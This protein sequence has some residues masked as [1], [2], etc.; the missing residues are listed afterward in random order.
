MNRIVIGNRTF[1]DSIITSI[2]MNESN[3]MIADTLAVDELV[4]DM[5]SNEDDGKVYTSN[6]EWYHT[7]NNE[8]FRVGEYYD[9]RTLT[10]G[11]AVSYYQDQKLVGKFALKSVKRKS[12]YIYE[13]SCISWVG[14]MDSITHYGGLYNGALLGDVL[15]D[16]LTTAGLTANTDFTIDLNVYNT[17]VAGWLPVDSCRA[18]MQ[19]A[20]FSCGASI[21]KDNYGILHF[22]FN[23]PTEAKEIDADATYEGGSFEYPALATKVIVT[24]HEYK[25]N[26]TIDKEVSLYDTG[27]ENVTDK[28]VTFSKPCYD[29]T[30]SGLTISESGANYAIV[31]GSG[32][33]IGKEY[34]H[35]T[36]IVEVETENYGLTDDYE[37]T[38]KDATLVTLLNSHNL[39]ER[40]SAYHSV[41]EIIGTSFVLDDE[42]PM[43][44]INIIDPYGTERV[45]Y[46]KEID[47]IGSGI[48]KANA[49][50]VTN[51]Q[52]NHVGN[53]Y[54]NYVIFTND[55][56]KIA[57]DPTHYK[58]ITNGTITLPADAVGTKGRFILFGGFKGGNGGYDGT[59]GQP[60]G[61][62]GSEGRS[63]WYTTIGRGGDGGQ[64]GTGGS[65]VMTLQA[66]VETLVGSYT[67]SVGA[68]GQGG[69][70]NGGVGQLGG[71]TTVVID[72]VTKDTDN[73]SL[74]TTGVANALSGDI[75]GMNGANGCAGGKGAEGGSQ[76][77][78]Y[79]YRWERE[80]VYY[81]P[82]GQS[83]T[84]RGITANG[85]TGGATSTYVVST[86][87]GS[88]NTG[89][90]GGGAAYNVAGGNGGSGSASGV[91]HATAGSG[92]QGADAPTPTSGVFATCGGGGYGGGGGGGAGKC[93][94]TGGSQSQG[95][96]YP[97]SGGRGGYG[98]A[99][100]NGGAGFILLYYN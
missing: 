83:V 23:L 42:K 82:N 49:K 80:D 7:V 5:Y 34:T 29:L 40:V 8:G 59:A 12:K 55:S 70:K 61:G 86:G 13:L 77:G 24:E 43:D 17:L 11:T 60:S 54:N 45:G 3:A 26:P 69:A 37:V 44:R 53:D 36:N 75:Y 89:G 84:Y 78:S 67:A 4:I 21:I 57:Q 81:A 87:Y 50:I 15:T 32:T 90:G 41:A 35:T 71:H 52:P 88:Y 58:P 19:Q 72:G 91:M 93:S 99:G 62:H 22:K 16:I 68:G 96:A 6:H 18:N 47:A 92:G 76:W 73:G 25:Q 65:G 100:G 46:I 20:L 64:G 14:I 95:Y 2:S 30:P 48:I 51:W 33:L 66:D 85:G 98:S 94:T 10:Y 1:T 31:S 79:S 28:V 56:A 63:E 97:G 9:F 38:V 39:A 74:N 27:A